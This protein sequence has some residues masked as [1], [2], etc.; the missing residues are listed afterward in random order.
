MQ[1]AIVVEGLRKEFSDTV[2]VR[3]VSFTAAAGEIVGLLGPNG[4]GKTTTIQMLLGI[5]SPTAGRIAILGHDLARERNH[6]L[7][8][9]NFSSAYVALP[10]RLTVRQNLDVYARL[11]DVRDRRE[12]I[13]ALLAYFDA[14]ALADRPVGTLSSGE[15]ARVNLCKALLNRPEV[16][17]LD[18]PTAS[19]DPDAADRARTQ[20]K[21]IRAAGGITLLYTSHNMAEVEDL[22]DRVIFIHAGT[23]LA[24]GTP[25]AVSRELLGTGVEEPALEEVFIRLARQRR[26]PPA[27]SAAEREP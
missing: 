27:V 16:L 10:P 2:A 6:V 21:Q 5:I 19:L 9:V 20:F 1:P 17:L 22:C 24:Q 26:E 23:V 3:D 8:R 25:L 13:D 4:A 15:T 18:E 12:R 11:Y 7:G 14:E